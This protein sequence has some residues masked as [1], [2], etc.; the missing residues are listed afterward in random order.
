MSN[1]R[2]V[3][4]VFVCFC[5]AEF[6]IICQRYHT[7]HT[8]ASENDS[9]SNRVINED[10]LHVFVL[11]MIVCRSAYGCQCP[12]HK[13]KGAHLFI[14]FLVPKKRV[15]VRMYLINTNMV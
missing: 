9:A 5:V 12:A 2:N 4:F 6:I 1:E 8:H 13:Q 7:F 15:C 11:D 3:V 14:N 10:D